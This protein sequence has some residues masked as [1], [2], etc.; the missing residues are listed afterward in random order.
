M[1]AVNVVYEALREKIIKGEFAPGQRLREEILA[2]DLG[3]GRTPVREALRRLKG[4]GLVEIVANRGA[5]VID[6]TD[7]DLEDTYELRAL[8][9]GFAARRAAEQGCPL[10]DLQKMCGQMEDLRADLSEQAYER[11]T[12]LNLQ[13]HHAIYTAAQIKVLPSLLTGVVQVPL[14]RHTFR[15][16]SQHELER[17][18]SQHRQLIEALRD[19]DGFLAESIMRSHILSGRSSLR[20]AARMST[21]FSES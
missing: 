18:F 16:Y 2:E 4:S 11:M 10:D 17:S 19:R 3:V 12:E 15:R 13:F 6:V 7:G 5:Q 9:E 8:L 14:V 21:E 20:R 1:V